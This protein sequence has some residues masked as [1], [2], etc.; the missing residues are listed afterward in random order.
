MKYHF[1]TTLDIKNIEVIYEI[2]EDDSD[3]QGYDIQVEY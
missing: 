2:V 1:N 3:R